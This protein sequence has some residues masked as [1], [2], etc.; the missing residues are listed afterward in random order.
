MKNLGRILSLT[1]ALVILSAS[2]AFAG[3]FNITGTYPE[4]NSKNVSLEN[5]GV[6][7]YTDGTF[8][9]DK[10][11]NA[12]DSAFQIYGPEGEKVNTKVYYSSKDPNMILVLADK[13]EEGKVYA[14]QSDS[15]YKLEI[16]SSLR[17]DNSNTLGRDMVITMHTV[18]QKRNNT[19]NTVMMFVLFGGIM[20]FSVRS[21]KKT[22][23][24]EAGKKKQETTT[25][26]PYKEAK[27]TGKSVSEIVEKDKA[28]KAKAA[29]KAAK[30]AEKA[31]KKAAL[32]DDEDELE[33]GHYRV[34]TRRSAL[35]VGS[36]YATEK[37]AKH[38][39]RR[40]QEAKWAAQAKKKG[41]KK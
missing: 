38:D 3:T 29:E 27:K 7:I 22:A 4:D 2:V 17:D 15:D 37:K 33:D 34:K 14:A 11:G 25:V 20:V 35:A 8:T 16:S 31:A 6:K 12:N 19:I 28:D 32:E 23:E 30:A 5:M 18:N 10:L 26:N 13:D 40:E 9:S 39:A 24:K 1:I 36:K 41:K 21:A